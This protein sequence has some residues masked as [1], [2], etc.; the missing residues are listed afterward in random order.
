MLLSSSMNHTPNSNK[1]DDDSVASSSRN[2]NSLDTSSITLQRKKRRR[3]KPRRTDPE[4][5]RRFKEA[6]Q[7]ALSSLA[8]VD[9]AAAAAPPRPEGLLRRKK[10]ARP[11]TE[12]GSAHHC[13]AMVHRS[14][15]YTVWGS[16][17]V[18]NRQ[19]AVHNPALTPGKAPLDRG[20]TWLVHLPKKTRSDP[21]LTLNRSFPNYSN[22]SDNNTTPTRTPAIRQREVMVGSLRANVK[23]QYQMTPEMRQH[24]ANVARSILSGERNKGAVDDEKVIDHH[25]SSPLSLSLE[26]DVA[27][28]VKQF[29]QHIANNGIGWTRCQ[30]NSTN[31]DLR[32]RR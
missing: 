29:E 4:R 31:C 6:F 26:S 28:F 7:V 24:V 25:F 16:S 10:W 19:A 11:P 3:W 15:D 13:R 32:Q 27:S 9:E 14:L 1:T 18:P 8:A 21:T 5:V 20:A 22:H 2:N 12:T 30:E 23:N 17:R